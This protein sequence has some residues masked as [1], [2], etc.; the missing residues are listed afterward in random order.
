MHRNEYTWPRVK[1]LWDG[2]SINSLKGIEQFITQVN[3]SPYPETKL[4][5]T[6]VH[7]TTILGGP[8]AISPQVD[9]WYE[10]ESRW[11]S[12]A[13]IINVDFIEK[14]K[15]VDCAIASNILRQVVEYDQ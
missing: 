13:F 5:S 10:A 14:T 11:A 7:V 2:K 3:S 4:W 12:K 6:Q 15:L 1:Q 8:T 9:M